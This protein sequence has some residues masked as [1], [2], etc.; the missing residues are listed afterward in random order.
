M[1][2]FLKF[3]PNSFY[4]D[5]TLCFVRLSYFN[6]IP[7][8]ALISTW[9]RP[10]QSHICIWAKH[11]GLQPSPPRIKTAKYKQIKKILMDRFFFSFRVQFH[12]EFIYYIFIYLKLL[13]YYFDSAIFWI[14]FL[15]FKIVDKL[16]FNYL[17]SIRLKI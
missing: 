12:S 15:P 16:I 5:P 3:F 17:K 9:T 4:V 10:E 13:M 6:F 2:A 14:D 7:F 1:G 8:S 11:T